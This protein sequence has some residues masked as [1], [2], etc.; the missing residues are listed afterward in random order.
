MLHYLLPQQQSALLEKCYEALLPDGLL[1]IRD[2][3]EELT[4]RHRGTKRSELFSTKIIRFNKTQNK[5]HFINSAFIKNWAIQKN[6]SLEIIDNTQKT[7]NLIFI[8][9]KN[10]S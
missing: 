4:K 5:L 8:L 7:S 1:I 10:P 2:G 3:V 9:K 6:L